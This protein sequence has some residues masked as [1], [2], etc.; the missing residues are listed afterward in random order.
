MQVK[1]KGNN[2]IINNASQNNPF[3]GV[4]VVNDKI[5]ISF[6]QG[7]HITEE[8]SELKKDIKLLL[9]T[10]ANNIITQTIDDISLNNEVSQFPIIAYIS[11]IKYY[12]HK[13]IYNENNLIIKKSQTGKISWNK[14][15][16]KISPQINNNSV[17]YLSF[18]VK[19]QKNISNIITEINKYCLNKAIQNIGWLYNLDTNFHNQIPTNNTTQYILILKSKLKEINN[20]D[21]KKLILSLIQILDEKTNNKL[22]NSIL[23]YGTYHF[24]YI[25]EKLINTHFGIK[26]KEKYFPKT[27]WILNGNLKFDNSKLEPDTIMITS[28]KEV[29]IIDAKY[30]KYGITKKPNHLPM[31]S[32]ISKQ[33]IYGEYTAK[34]LNT[35][36]VYN[37]FLMPY[38]N[39]GQSNLIMEKIGY[40]YSEWK[41]NDKPYE[42]ING[43]IIDT[44]YIMQHPINNRK[45]DQKALRDC[46]LN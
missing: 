9:K 2:L 21:D 39:K 27:Y 10:I 23:L 34:I 5:Y 7:F 24:E 46:I 16:K 14:T 3:V 22:E 38:D 20:D 8:K 28:N 26:N 45:E 33:I 41:D 11:V 30:Y 40:A 31:T 4:Q 42:I 13:G 25:W 32:S 43:V 44:K 18:L 29:I 37:V 15:L 35:N 19:K 12:L 17:I 6:P 36:S 1:I